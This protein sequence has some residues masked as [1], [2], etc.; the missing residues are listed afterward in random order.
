MGVSHRCCKDANGLKTPGDIRIG[1]GVAFP[2]LSILWKASTVLVCW[3]WCTLGKNL[4]ISWKLT[5][6]CTRNT[7]LHD[8]AVNRYCRCR[9]CMRRN[10]R[11]GW[12]S[13][14]FSEATHDVRERV[15]RSHKPGKCQGI[16]GELTEVWVAHAGTRIHAAAAMKRMLDAPDVARARMAIVW[17]CANYLNIVYSLSTCSA[18]RRNL[19]PST[20]GESCVDV[21]RPPYPAIATSQSRTVWGVHGKNWLLCS[22][23]RCLTPSCARG[24]SINEYQL[25]KQRPGCPFSTSRE[26]KIIMKN[27]FFSRSAPPDVLSE[28]NN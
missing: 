21:C 17:C 19:G 1:E 11:P 15:F 10:F 27:A 24:G 28:V 18:P 13:P 26:K 22:P 16:C 12:R 2:A 9:I 20:R 3:F 23:T 14:P 25:R 7:G 8:E 6:S 4:R 5:S